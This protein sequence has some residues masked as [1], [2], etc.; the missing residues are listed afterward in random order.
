MTNKLSTGAQ[1]RLDELQSLPL[2][3]AAVSCLLPEIILKLPA[4]P[5][6]KRIVTEL[7]NWLAKN[8]N[9]CH[10]FADPTALYPFEGVNERVKNQILAG[11]TGIGEHN[12]TLESPFDWDGP[13]GSSRSHR[14][15]INAWLMLGELLRSHSIEG[16]EKAYDIAKAIAIDWIEHHIFGERND[17]FAWY[18]MGVGQRSCMLSYIVHCSIMKFKSGIFSWIFGS[19]SR[20]SNEILKLIV[21]SEIHMIELMDEE[22]LALHSNH[23]LFQMSGLLS[24]S[25]TLPFMSA[26]KRSHTFSIDNIEKMLQSHFF[27][28][29]FHKEHSPMYHMYMTNYIV[30][31]RLAGWIDGNTDLHNLAKRAEETA[32]WY[33]LPDQTILPLGDSKSTYPFRSAC[34]FNLNVDAVG[35][36]SAPDGLY[37][38]KEGGLAIL[39]SHSKGSAREHLTFS[40]QFH[41]RMHKHSDDMSIHYCVFGRQYLVDSGTFTY[42]YD[43]PERM[44]IESTKAHNA[45]TI[46]GLNYSRFRNDIYG[47]CLKLATQIGPYTLMEGFMHH[48]RLIPSAIPNNKVKTSDSTPVDIKHRRRLFT[49]PGKFLVVLDEINSESNHEYTQW[50]HLDPSLS[51]EDNSDNILRVKEGNKSHSSIHF[52][53]EE[54]CNFNVKMLRGNK[55]PELQGWCSKDGKRLVEN[56]AIGLQTTSKSTHLLTLFDLTNSAKKPYLKIGTGGKYLRFTVEIEQRKYDIISREKFGANRSILCKVDDEEFTLE[57]EEA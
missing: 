16:N 48:R 36:L 4:N 2:E 55:N 15:K 18:D 1:E 30:Q 9:T 23:G 56:T 53:V 39:S 7:R 6:S 28:D 29:G 17:D 54:S 13:N 34:L 22:R 57:I 32:S 46:D 52:I 8:S 25:E 14:Y 41:S 10:L 42:Q 26:S 40:A 24:L 44:Y 19:T 45:L 51:I 43:A 47:S 31:M 33:I 49:V 5:S 37:Q 12:Y 3:E 27:K 38:H 35:K 11:Y 50:F 21:A 20:A